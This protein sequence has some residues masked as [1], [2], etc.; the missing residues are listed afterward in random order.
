MHKLKTI[1][2][3]LEL[4][5]QYDYQIAKVARKTGINPRTIKSWYDKQ[6]KGQ[7][8][9][10]EN[11]K[12]TSKFTHSMKKAVLDYYFEHGRSA[13]RQQNILDTRQERP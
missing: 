1:Q 3:T 6:S 8:L 4:L 12:K 10:I 5:K 13:S 2:K 11:K 7:T 9:L